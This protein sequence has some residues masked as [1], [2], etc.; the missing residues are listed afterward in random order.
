MRTTLW[1]ACGLAAGL[2]VA[3]DAV[4][5]PPFAGAEEF[6]QKNCVAC[7]SGKA[8]KAG[9]DLTKLAYEPASPDNF[10]TWVKV[11][12]RVSTR[13]MP[14]AGMPRPTAASEKQFV[15]GLATALAG[16]EQTVYAE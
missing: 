12:D 14:P 9:L 15:E 16:F 1:F 6:V 11:H 3:F 7:H 5:A 10:A 13:E 2:F 4:A 8:A